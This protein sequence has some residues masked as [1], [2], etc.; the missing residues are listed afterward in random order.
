MEKVETT[1]ET[2]WATIKEGEKIIHDNVEVELNTAKFPFEHK[3][4]HGSFKVYPDRPWV[5]GFYKLVLRDGRSYQIVI[6][7]VRSKGR[8]TILVRFLVTPEE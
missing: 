4:L 5:P 6:K 3:V 1:V 2:A 8:E 7:E